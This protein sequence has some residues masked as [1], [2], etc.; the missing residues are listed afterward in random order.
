MFFSKVVCITRGLLW[1]ITRNS[2]TAHHHD[3]GSQAILIMAMVP[4]VLHFLTLSWERTVLRSFPGLP[5]VQ[6]SL[7]GIR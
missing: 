7:P 1:E 3:T 6:A 5:F 2:E 4:G